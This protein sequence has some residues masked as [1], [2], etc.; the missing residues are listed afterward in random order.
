MYTDIPKEICVRRVSERMDTSKNVYSEYS[1][2]EDLKEHLG[3]VV[4]NANADAIIDGTKDREIVL[5][6]MLDLDFAS[7]FIRSQ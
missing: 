6:D 4:V 7:S 1:L 3:N 2:K 5:K